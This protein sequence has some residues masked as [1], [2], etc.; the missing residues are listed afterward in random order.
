MKFKNL[1]R[2]VFL[3]AFSLNV[4]TAWCQ[5]PLLSVQTYDGI[6][7]VQ[8]YLRVQFQSPF[9]DSTWLPS[10]FTVAYRYVDPLALFSTFPDYAPTDRRQSQLQ[11]RWNLARCAVVQYTGIENPR[12]VAARIAKLNN[13]TLAE[14]WYPMDVN[15][16]P[17]DP[18][19][20]EQEA[21]Q[22]INMEEAWDITKG[23]PDV[24]VAVIDNGVDQSHE[25]LKPALWTNSAEIPLNNIDDDNNGV[26][27]DYQGAN[28][29]WQQDGTQPGVTANTG[30]GG[31]GTNVAGICS[32]KGSNDKGITGIAHSCSLFPIKVAPR[33]TGSILYGYDG[34][35][36]ASQM[37]FKVANCSWGSHPGQGMAPRPYSA[38]SNLIT[39]YCIAHGMV[40][41]SSAGNHG[42]G[43]QGAGW[44][45]FNYPAAFDG[46]IGTGELTTGDKVS[47]SSGLGTN[48]D[49]MAPSNG[50][51]TTVHGGSYSSQGINGTSFAAPFAAGVA[52]L[53]VSKYPNFTAQQVAA[54][55]Q[56]TAD[57]VVTLNS[58]YQGVLPGRINA[59]KAL[60]TNPETVCGFS[61][62]QVQITNTAGTVI[63]RYTTGDTIDILV[64]LKN[65]LG[66]ASQIVITPELADEADWSVS[67]SGNPLTVN[68]VTPGIRITA[69]PYRVVLGEIGK[70]PLVFELQYRNNEQFGRLNWNV[71]PG[72]K[73][74]TIE[75]DKL[76]YSIGDHGMFGYA[77]TM[78][79]NT[80]ADGGGAGWKTGNQK[81]SW[82]GGLLAAEAD[83]RAV[84]AYNNRD[85][86]SDFAAEQPFAAPHPTSAVLTDSVFPNRSIGLRIR[87]HCW[88]PV[89]S[90]AA[91]VIDIEV[92]NHTASPLT[93]VAA[94]Y[95]FDFDIGPSGAEN[96]TRRAQSAIP[97]NPAI[98]GGALLF[99]RDGFPMVVTIAAYTSD[100]PGVPQAVGM[101]TW[102]IV[103][104]SDRLTDQDVINLLNSGT[105]DRNNAPDDMCSV[106]GMR[107]P[108]VLQPGERKAFSIVIGVGKTEQEANQAVRETIQ[109]ATTV[110][111]VP[112]SSLSVWPQPAR[113]SIAVILPAGTT[114]VEVAD[115]LGRTVYSS[116]TFADRITI[117]TSQW[118]A[119]FYTILATS[120]RTMVRH[121]LVIVR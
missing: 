21:L 18:L 56:V 49:I 79:N 20:S 15:Y 16:V 19:F 47:P 85:D 93:D 116:R 117:G 90:N 57:P 71:F 69:G 9:F 75:N 109:S 92:E 100:H 107:F 105:P 55:L 25:D 67:F 6:P 4:V 97:D 29:T 35:L 8:G 112:H 114:S 45:E 17:N 13:V 10:G 36:Y 27:D 31:H 62:E 87:E 51:L 98:N 58:A 95:L 32:A 43:L 37:G 80:I 66:T 86:N 53:I 111:E 38:I 72:S 70:L 52:A 104:D 91:T 14:P 59:A 73:M 81:F 2:F 115:A 108:G 54:L 24:V 120:N 12:Y 103:D 106:V 99:E 22:V 33:G 7:M 61:I 110:R 50:A 63:T 78:T 30:S 94:G 5:L 113:E 101:P 84:K 65:Q 44:K 102:E 76:I 121:P 89:S 39:D 68:E 3:F 28:L 48:A 26:V 11:A 60:G 34:L 42:N 119:G 77:S 96:I 41:T 64:F 1:L 46:V 74:T 40:I 82:V 23:S 88:F 83:T 118:P